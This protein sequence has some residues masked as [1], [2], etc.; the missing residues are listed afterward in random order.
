M[1]KSLK[2]LVCTMYAIILF[3]GLNLLVNATEL[4]S[5][6]KSEEVIAKISVTDDTLINIKKDEKQ[7]EKLNLKSEESLLQKTKKEPE[8]VKLQIEEN[9][10]NKKFEKKFDT[11]VIKDIKLIGKQQFIY[12]GI[13]QSNG[14]SHAVSDNEIG[15][16][17]FEGH[18]RDKA[19]TFFL[20][21]MLPYS[22]TPKYESQAHRLF[23]FY[24]KRPVDQ[25]HSITL[26]QQRTPNTFEGSISAFNS[27]T[28]RRSQFASKYSNITS[29][30]AK[31]SGDWDRVEYHLGVFDTGRFLKDAFEAPPEFAGLV[32]LKPI[33][34]TKKYGKLKVG[35]SYNGGKRDYSYN[36]SSVHLLYDYKK[37]HFNSE[38][39]Y[40]NG[41]SGH[42]ISNAK[43]YGYQT[44]FLYDITS[45][46]QSFCRLDTL[47]ANT[48]L[49]GQIS[50]EY[51]AGIHYY[52]KGKKARLT[53]S[54][55]HNNNDIKP[56]SNRLFSMLELLL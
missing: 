13:K 1:Y 29:I 14:I 3:T 27:P 48:A 5:Q 52:L 55:I 11:G 40:A 4:P 56:D 23:E 2:Y 19:N 33:K 49:N 20:F 47:N 38:Y 46:I 25:H 53:L 50:T 26:G 37:Y 41:Y 32:S 21:D 34:N 39:A 45:K 15:L 7:P 54:Y 30:G 6:E 9:I 24:I 28:G 10:F 35:G 8:V 51:T 31:V 22:D 16:W 18:L 43:S 36:V 12:T 17:G 44:T 42:S